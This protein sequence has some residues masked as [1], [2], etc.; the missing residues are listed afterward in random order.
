[1]SFGRRLQHLLSFR[2]LWYFNAKVRYYCSLAIFYTVQEIGVGWRSYVEKT[3][4]SCLD[5]HCW[6]QSN[7]YFS[8]LSSQ[9]VYKSKVV[10][11]IN[12]DRSPKSAHLLPDKSLEI[13]NG[14]Y[15]SWNRSSFDGSTLVKVLF[16]P[17]WIRI[18]FTLTLITQNKIYSD[19]CRL[20]Y[21]N[22]HPLSTASKLKFIWIAQSAWEE[23]ENILKFIH[24]AANL[25]E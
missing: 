3:V 19:W 9:L 1:M 13:F 5:K 2:E 18:L 8:L 17:L 16:T 22:F 14:F 25:H 4:L 21:N 15:W 11:V 24:I 20:Q 10:K 7:K 12:A 23:L 6:V